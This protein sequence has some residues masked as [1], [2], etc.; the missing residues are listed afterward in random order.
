MNRVTY[1][2]EDSDIA[3]GSVWKSN[4][5]IVAILSI[6]A[7]LE[8]LSIS[9]KD[10]LP[11]YEEMKEA[12]YQLMSQNINVAQI[13]PPKENFINVHDYCL[14]LWE[15]NESEYNRNS[16][17]TSNAPEIVSYLENVGIVDNISK[18]VIFPFNAENLKGESSGTIRDLVKGINV[19]GIKFMYINGIITAAPNFIDNERFNN[20]KRYTSYAELTSDI[21]P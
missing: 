4:T 21:F 7:G 3:I 5:G 13:F 20:A 8:H 18:T 17:N 11:T 14:H 6:D 16:T 2:K 19:A 10:R 1:K 15:L 12:R 9:H